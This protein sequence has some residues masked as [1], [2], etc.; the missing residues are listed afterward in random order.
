MYISDTDV[1]MEIDTH[2]KGDSDDKH[3][4]LPLLLLLSLQV[5]SFVVSMLIH[6]LNPYHS[7]LDRG[8]LV[9]VIYSMF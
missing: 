5:R 6:H 3:L 1:E 7:Q 8:T 4:L 2:N 9:R